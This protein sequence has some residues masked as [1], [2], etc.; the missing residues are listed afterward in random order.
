MKVGAHGDA[1][2][3]EGSGQGWTRSFLDEAELA[4]PASPMA[5]KT[6]AFPR[7][8]LWPVFMHA[9]ASSSSSKPPSAPGVCFSR[10]FL[11]SIGHP[12]PPCICGVM[13]PRMGA[14]HHPSALPEAFALSGDSHP[15]QVTVTGW[16]WLLSRQMGLFCCDS[17]PPWVGRAGSFLALNYPR[18]FSL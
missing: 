12:P 7:N 11:K 3:H 4:D 18:K 14:S 2:G 13:A 8:P 1:G 10:I 15:R 16:G 9:R 5:D 17:S 6:R